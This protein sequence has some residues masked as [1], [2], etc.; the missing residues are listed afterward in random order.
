MT[1]RCWPVVLHIPLWMW[2]RFL[3]DCNSAMKAWLQILK[4]SFPGGGCYLVYACQL[5]HIP[6]THSWSIFHMF[7]L[8]KRPNHSSNCS[9]L[10]TYILRSSQLSFPCSGSTLPRV[11][12]RLT[13]PVSGL[14]VDLAMLS[15]HSEFILPLLII[16]PKEPDL[17]L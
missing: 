10:L 11:P 14:V 8:L 15:S 7:F 5:L 12:A 17:I 9:L 16:S 4:N 3:Q 13:Q 2:R 6:A 1:A